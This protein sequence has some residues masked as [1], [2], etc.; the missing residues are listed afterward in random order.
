MEKFVKNLEQCN[1]K[2]VIIIDPHLRINS[3]KKQ[4]VEDEINSTEPKMELKDK[5]H[6]TEQKEEE[7]N[8]HI[9]EQ[10]FKEGII[11]Y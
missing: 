6:E 9:S 5:I 1:R 11:I 4:I 7:D 8:Y 2:L 3:G 10:L